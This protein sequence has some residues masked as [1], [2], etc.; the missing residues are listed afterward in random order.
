M[1][2]VSCSVSPKWH[3]HGCNQCRVSCPLVYDLG[4]C[5]SC[6]PYSYFGDP[7]TLPREGRH[8]FH[9][10]Y[11]SYEWKLFNLVT[12]AGSSLVSW[13]LIL[14]F[15]MRNLFILCKV[16]PLTLGGS[17][18]NILG[19][20]STGYYWLLPYHF[21][22]QAVRWRPFIRKFDD[23]TS[24]SLHVGMIGVIFRSIPVSWLRLW[25]F[26]VVPWLLQSGV[27]VCGTTENLWMLTG[28]PMGFLETKRVDSN[29]S[30]YHLN[31]CHMEKGESKTQPRPLPAALFQHIVLRWFFT[32]Q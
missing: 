21:V 12:D 17:P 31:H 6:A 10:T 26:H 2:C 3:W 7:P 5:S 25:K 29:A 19:S 22:R 32:C 15:L 14:T 8:F 20:L 23:L 9:I 30:E 16:H 28:N 13:L 4:R 24:P 11:R 27:N 18:V 1:F